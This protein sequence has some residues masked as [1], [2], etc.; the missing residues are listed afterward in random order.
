MNSARA[1]HAATLLND[2]KVLVVGGTSKGS[3]LELYDPAAGTFTA[4][5]STNANGDYGSTATLLNNGKVLVT[6]PLN[7]SSNRPPVFG[8]YDPATGTVTP[9]G[10]MNTS[11]TYGFTAT[12]LK[13]G[14]VLVTG[15]VGVVN[16]PS[17]VLAS[18][19]LYD[20]ATGTFVLAQP[21]MER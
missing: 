20:P 13:D 6:G 21:E 19:E 12:L 9:T 14:R 18:A 15:G 5:G 3:S 11:R 2:G 4:M 1:S 17:P 16:A 8:L 10:S 7:G